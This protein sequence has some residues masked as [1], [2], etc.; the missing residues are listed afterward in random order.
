VTPP[1]VLDTCALLFWTVEPA[2]LTHAARAAIDR[3][4]ESPAL[5]CTASIWEIALKARAGKLNLNMTT[6]DYVH[7]LR[8]LPVELISPDAQLWIDSVELAWTHRDPVDRLVV[9]LAQS[10]NAALCTSDTEIRAFYQK[11]VW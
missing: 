6:R 3:F 8:R 4:D 2:R 11:V 7:R 9:A 5:V 10:R 1:T